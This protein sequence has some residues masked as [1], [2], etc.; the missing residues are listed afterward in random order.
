MVSI[1]NF[2]VCKNR[3]LIYLGPMYRVALNYCT[4]KHTTRM[5]FKFQSLNF[6]LK[7]IITATAL[8]KTAVLLWNT[9][10]LIHGGSSEK[11]RNHGN[12]LEGRQTPSHP[13]A[14]LPS[15]SASSI[16]N[17]SFHPSILGREAC[18]GGSQRLM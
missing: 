10:L 16:H 8:G 1:Y 15:L 4:P 7:I 3:Y 17:P 13:V 5:V 11:T 18:S 9:S 12:S 2:H 14:P 6:H